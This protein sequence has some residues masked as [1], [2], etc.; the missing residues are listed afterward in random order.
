MRKKIFRIEKLTGQVVHENW[1]EKANLSNLE[2]ENEDT[3][4]TELFNEDGLF[5]ALNLVS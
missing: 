2:K 3:L 5:G 4:T 1:C